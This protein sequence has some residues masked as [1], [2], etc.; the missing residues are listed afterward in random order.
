MSGNRSLKTR[1][2]AQKSNGRIVIE[3]V[4]SFVISLAILLAF[5]NPAQILY[6]SFFLATI[7]RLILIEVFFRVFQRTHSETVKAV[8]QNVVRPPRE[9]KRPLQQQLAQPPP[10]WRWLC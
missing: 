3:A 6:G 10:C 7:T 5:D 9:G 2:R 1:R 4:I 8:L